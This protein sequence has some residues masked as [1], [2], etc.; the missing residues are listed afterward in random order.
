MPSVFF[1]ELVPTLAVSL[2]GVG[3]S[4]ARTPK[5]VDPSSHHFEMIGI[6]ALAIL[7]EVIN[8]HALGNFANQDG[9]CMTMRVNMLRP[10]GSVSIWNGVLAIALTGRCGSP[11]PAV[12]RCINLGPE[13]IFVHVFARQFWRR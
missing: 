6:N 12:T 7:A 10:A 1:G 11:R 13:A 2:A 3:V 9:P 5:V 8:D 4:E